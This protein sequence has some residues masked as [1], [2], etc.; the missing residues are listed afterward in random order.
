MSYA[1][2]MAKKEAK[3]CPFCGSNNI[4]YK[5]TTTHGH[6][7]SFFEG[8]IWCEDCTTDGPKV[9]GYGLSTKED[10]LEAWNKWNDR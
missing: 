8:S 9:A 10:E 6:G 7:E 5:V 2:D 4:E 3:P 1:I